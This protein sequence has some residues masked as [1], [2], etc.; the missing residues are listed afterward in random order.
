MASAYFPLTDEIVLAIA[1]LYSH[2]MA[3]CIVNDLQAQLEKI[4]TRSA[5]GLVEVLGNVCRTLKESAPDYVKGY[6]DGVAYSLQA[7]TD[8]PQQIKREESD[9]SHRLVPRFDDSND[10]NRTPLPKAIAETRHA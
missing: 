1:D 6:I 10:S 9:F 3:E 5:I 8:T 2:E 4:P 7:A